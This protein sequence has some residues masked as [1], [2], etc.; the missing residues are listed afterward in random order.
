MAN[1]SVTATATL[2][3]FLRCCINTRMRDL[4][5][6]PWPNYSLLLIGVKAAAAW[7]M[8]R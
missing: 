2:R 1:F 8:P 3:P 5:A 4:C 6:A 7:L